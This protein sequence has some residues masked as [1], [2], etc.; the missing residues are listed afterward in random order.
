VSTQIATTLICDGCLLAIEDSPG[1]SLQ[2]D[3]KVLDYHD[4]KCLKL[5]GDN[6][7]AE[8]LQ[9]V[10]TAEASVEASLEVAING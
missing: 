1:L 3:G 6:S 4:S 8:H 5:Y 2:K 10:A 7:I 9:K